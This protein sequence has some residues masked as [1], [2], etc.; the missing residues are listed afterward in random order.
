MDLSRLLAETS[1]SIHEQKY[2]FI[3]VDWGRASDV[4]ELDPVATCR[5]QEGLSGVVEQQLAD[6][7]GLVYDGVFRMITLGVPSSLHAVGLTAAVSTALA[8]CG[9]AANIVAGRHH[10]HIFVPADRANEALALLED[11]Q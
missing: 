10:D 1:P 3:S 9:I 7:H 6:D 8:R 2:V 11:L 5:E 4:Y